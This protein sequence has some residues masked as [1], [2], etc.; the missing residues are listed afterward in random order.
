MESRMTKKI[1]RQS[2]TD[3]IVV[4]LRRRIIAGELAEGTPLRQE[5][6]AI[7]LG[8]SRIPIREAIRQLEAEGFVQSELHKGTV[9][10]ALSLAE[11][12]ELFDIRIHLETWL[13]EMAIPRLS[14]ADLRRAE[15]LT[16]E[17]LT[18]GNGENWGDLNW[19][20]HETLYA[21]SGRT[22]ALKLLKSVHDNA[23]RYIN[24]QIAVAQDVELELSDHRAILAYAK[25]KDAER[26]VETLRKHIQR[27]ANN[28]MK[29]L[30]ESRSDQREQQ[31]A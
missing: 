1:G 21:P 6:L 7:E 11:I 22:V 8:V 16:D 3:Q 10:K 12:Q 4:E 5:A 14:E 9:V 25:L 28:L 17:T 13:F 24:L 27:V 31:T 19:Q 29:S 30:I 18:E 23:N 26:A 20:F 2:L 15:Q